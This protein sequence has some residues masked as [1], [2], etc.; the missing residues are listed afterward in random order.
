MPNYHAVPPGSLELLRKFDTP[1]VCN[2]IELFDH[3]PRCAGYMDARIRACFPKM[4]PMVGYAVTATF[5][6]AAPPRSGN[7]YASLSDILAAFA[8]LTG[9]AVVVVQDLD[10]PTASAMFGEVVCTAFKSF[11]AAGL[12][13]NGAARDID[14]V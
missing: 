14:Q 9:P 3:R 2:V 6:S 10:D 11:G 8:E 7:V 4:P 1:T 5:R 13:T 12:V